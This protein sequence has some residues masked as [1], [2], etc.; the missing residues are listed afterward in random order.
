MEKMSIIGELINKN[1]NL[2]NGW[3]Y[4]LSELISDKPT[5]NLEIINAIYS[6]LIQNKFF[7]LILDIIDFIID[8][9]NENIINML[10]IQ[11]T[12]SL[13]H[14]NSNKGFQTSEETAM[15]N[16]FLFQKIYKKYGNQFNKI[17][18]YYEGIKS[19]GI[20]FPN[21]EI[22]IQTYLKYITEDEIEETKN[23]SEHQKSILSR[24]LMKTIHS[25]INPYS[26][27]VSLEP[28]NQNKSKN[29]SGSQEN[30]KKEDDKL[31]NLNQNNY[32]YMKN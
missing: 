4:F 9:G 19:Q 20:E 3:K 16:L 23:F 31:N 17:K 5:V 15:K 26:K 18:E 7:D 22:K 1:G 12:Q 6:S 25:E 21:D 28:Q 10:L 24:D 13:Y 8:Y 14:L 11:C 29:D 27:R 32:I 2:K 30:Q